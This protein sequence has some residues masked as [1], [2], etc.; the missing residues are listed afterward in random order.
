[1][2]RPDSASGSCARV[3]HPPPAPSSRHNPLVDGAVRPDRRRLRDALVRGAVSLLDHRGGLGVVGAAMATV[4][5]VRPRAAAST[6]LVRDVLFAMFPFVL[7]RRAVQAFTQR[8][9]N[10]V[11]TGTN[12]RCSCS[13][14]CWWVGQSRLGQ[15]A[16]RPGTGR[17]CGRDERRPRRA[18]GRH[19][20]DRRLHGWM[21]RRS[22]VLEIAQWGKSG[23]WLGWGPRPSLERLAIQINRYRARCHRCR[24]H[25][26]GGSIVTL[27][28]ARDA[29][30]DRA[31]SARPPECSLQRRSTCLFG[32][33]RHKSN[34]SGNPLLP[35]ATIS[36]G[37]APIPG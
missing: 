22:R 23:R 19:D 10:V 26:G 34:C 1:V 13:H 21:R 8:S 11:S 25:S 28:A 4:R 16:W 24:S 20:R 31:G 32:H 7:D 17:A 37:A 29:T 36:T 33:A 9:R 6:P 5:R 2:E 14:A 35:Q 3:G 30:A 15:G 18:E 27:M 12:R